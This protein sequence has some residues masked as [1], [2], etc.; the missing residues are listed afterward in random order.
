MANQKI[1]KGAE[2][3]EPIALERT[4]DVLRSTNGSRKEG[5]IV[6]GFALETNDQLANGTRKLKEKALDFLV[7]NSA[8]EPDAGFDVPT[9]RVT[10][11][12][13]DGGAEELP[14][15]TK[16]AVAD[17]IIARITSLLTAAR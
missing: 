14:L 3:P 5:A 2:E 17:D 16:D 1:K 7:L 9:N 13:P 15:M 8:N 6:V 4:P 12:T 10:I 11:L